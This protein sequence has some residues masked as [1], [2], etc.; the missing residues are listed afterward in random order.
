MG[1]ITPILALQPLE[2]SELGQ[3]STRDQQWLNAYDINVQV[4][5]NLSTHPKRFQVM[6]SSDRDN[7]M[8]A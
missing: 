6:I 5:Q 2:P 8:V 4:Y 3:K 7:A 1:R